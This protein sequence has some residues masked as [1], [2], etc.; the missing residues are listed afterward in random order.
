MPCACQQ[1]ASTARH[2]PARDLSVVEERA[3]EAVVALPLAAGQHLVAEHPELVRGVVV[4]RV[5]LAAIVAVLPVVRVGLAAIV[6]VLHERARL[7]PPAGACHA[8]MPIIV[9]EARPR[10]AEQRS[11]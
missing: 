1:Q 4:V 5:R 7:S 9:V 2:A 11:T 6:A 8:R 3:L 10:P